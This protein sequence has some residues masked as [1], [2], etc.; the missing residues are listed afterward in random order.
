MQMGIKWFPLLAQDVLG[1]GAHGRKAFYFQLRHLGRGQDGILDLFGYPADY[2]LSDPGKFR[3]DGLTVA[4]G[5]RVAL[6]FGR[7]AKK[8]EKEAE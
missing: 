2:R 7:K 6:P 3:V 1:Q 8:K 5:M 4:A